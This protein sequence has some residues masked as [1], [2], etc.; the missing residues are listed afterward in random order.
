MNVPEHELRIDLA[1]LAP[2]RGQDGADLARGSD[3]EIE[4]PEARLPPR[5]I[6]CRRRRTK[7]P[8]MCVSRDADYPPPGIDALRRPV[9]NAFADRILPRPHTTRDRFAHDR[10]ELGVF[11]IRVLEWSSA[12][13]RRPERTE[14]LLSSA[15]DGD[16]RI[17]GTTRF[18]L[19]FTIESSKKHVVADQRRDQ[20]GGDG[21]HAR[22]CAP[23]SYDVFAER[24]H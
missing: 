15:L 23:S 21:D 4:L 5:H 7:H 8:Q 11:S 16:D 10:Y 19:P 13:K 14:V 1:R 22:N 18:R 2:K 6:H 9:V 24:I 17:R 12:Q 20:R 3:R